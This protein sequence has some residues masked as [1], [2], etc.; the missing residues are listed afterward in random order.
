MKVIGIDIGTTTISTVVAETKDQVMIEAGTVPNE[1][2]METENEWERIQNVA[3]IVEKA[4]KVLDDLITAFRDVAYIGLTGQMHGIVYVDKNG[5]CVSPLYTW[6]DGRGN[7]ILPEKGKSLV[8]W[9]CDVCKV[10]VATGYGLVTHT[11]NLIYHLVPED[12]V[13]LCTISDYLGMVLTERKAPLLHVSNASS[14]GFF[15]IIKGRF[16]EEELKKIG[17]DTGILPEVTDEIQILGSYKGIPVGIGIGDNQ[18]SFLGSVG[19]QE[20]GILLNMGTG[21][22]ISV[23]S[24]TYFSMKGI[25]TRPFIN[26]KYL[27]VG[28]SLCGGRAYAVLEKFFRSYAEAAGAGNGCQYELMA[29]L[30]AEGERKDD[31]MRVDTTFNGTRTNPLKRGSIFNISEDNFTPSGIIYGVLEGMARELYDMF[32][33]IKDETGIEAKLLVASGNGLRKNELLCKICSRMFGTELV[34]APCKEE[35][36]MGAALSIRNRQEQ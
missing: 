30:G 9:I 34:L 25:E 11:Y 28:A 22:Q 12:A 3:V 7:V 33:K 4:Q 14:L 1:S 36:A 24:D 15:D 27:L 17:V 8:S 32:E 31:G 5:K 18:A 35:A 10:N 19:V 29:K 16:M 6:Q 13:Y 23:L 20:G 21:G 2:Y 26:G